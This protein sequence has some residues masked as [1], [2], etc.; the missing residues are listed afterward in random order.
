MPKCV[1]VAA[2]LATSLAGCGGSTTPRA[3][4][5]VL[6]EWYPDGAS[7]KSIVVR[8]ISLAPPSESVVPESHAAAVHAS[9]SADGSEIAW[10]LLDT[11]TDEASVWTAEAD[12]SNA[13]QRVACQGAP[14]VE[15]S[16]PM[17]S[18]DG[19]RMLVTRFDK[20]HDG[21]WGASHLV[22]VDL[23]TDEQQII[24]STP[25]GYSSFYS[26]TWSPDGT[27]VAAQLEYYPSDGQDEIVA[28]EIVVVDTDP[29][30]ADA[31]IAITPPE[32]FG[33]YP[34]W[35]PTDDQI[36]FASWDLNGWSGDEP[37]QL[38]TVASDGSHLRQVTNVGAS[39]GRRPG[40]ASWT[41]DGK[42][43]IASIGVVVGGR[44]VDVK[45]AWVDPATGAIDQTTVSGAMPALQP[46]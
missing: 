31:P 9:W 6:F 41:P 11:S 35:H 40:E 30:T 27:H 10:E 14:C 26:A 33:G 1:V 7:E 3:D 29:T 15:V 12:G 45:I 21:Q 22:V 34:R 16:Y 44:V 39:E 38:Y 13:R 4:P 18:P 2:F 8:D 23:T 5:L 36:V 20:N 28:S 46:A 32:L 19:S 17:F 24:A 42:Q 43:L 25:D 37:S